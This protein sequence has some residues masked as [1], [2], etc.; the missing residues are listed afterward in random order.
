MMRGLIKIYSHRSALL[1][2]TVALIMGLG[3]WAAQWKAKQAERELR[4]GLLQQ[5]T[6]IA[7]TIDPE[8]VKVLTFTDSDK[9]NAAFDRI[10]RQMVAYRR[11]IPQCA[12]YSMALRNETIIFGPESHVEPEPSSGE[13]SSYRAGMTYEQPSDG[14]FQAFRV[15]QPITIGPYTDEYGVFISGLAP[16]LD[17]KTREVVLVVG[18]DIMYDQWSSKIAHARYGPIAASLSLI[19]IIV[20]GFMLTL[21]RNCLSVWW[22][23]RLRHIETA[24]VAAICMFLTIFITRIAIEI[25]HNSLE[26]TFYKYSDARAAS[27]RDSFRNVNTNI[28]ALGR[29]FEYDSEISRDDFDRFTI[30]MLETSSIFAYQWIPTVSFKKKIDVETTAAAESIE[31][32][33]IWELNSAGEKIKAQTRDVYYPIRHISPSEGNEMMIGFDLGSEKLRRAAIEKAADTK[34][35]TATDPVIL[36]QQKDQLKSMLI[37]RPVFKDTVHSDAEPNIGTH[38]SPTLTGF[39]SAVLTMQALF[40]N[41]IKDNADLSSLIDTDILDVMSEPPVVLAHT[42]QTPTRKIVKGKGSHQIKQIY[43]LFAFDRSFAIISYPNE[44]FYAQNRPVMAFITGSS[45]L[46]ITIILTT[47]IGFLRNHQTVLENQVKQRTNDIREREERLSTTLN[48]IGDAV[49]ATDAAGNIT[50]MNPVAEELT[51]WTFLEADGRPLTEIFIIRNSTTNEPVSDPVREVLETGNVVGMANHTSLIS[52][53]GTQRQIADSAAPIRQSDGSI[54]GVVLVFH[55][56]TE[57][58]RMQTTLIESEARFRT[59]ANSGQ[60]LVWTSGLDKKCDYLNEP[61]L[62][63]TGSTLD[64]QKAYDRLD[65]VHPDDREAMMDVYDKSFDLREKFNIEYRLRRQDG[66]YRWI[67]D[68]GTPRYDSKGEFLGYI[69]HCIDINERVNAQLRLKQAKDELEEANIRLQEAATQ[70]KQMAIESQAAN[71]AKGQFLANMSHEIRTPM[72]GVIGMTLLLMETELDEEQRRYAEIVCSSGKA[73]LSLINEILDFSK[74]EADKL[75]LES[76]EFNLREII[77][78]TAE[79]LAFRAQEKGLELVSRIEPRLQTGLIGDP[80]RLRQVLI[81][82]GGNAV[83]FTSEGEIQINAMLESETDTQ[84]IVRFEVQD[85][86]IGIPVDKTHLLFNPFQQVDYSHTRKFSGTGLGLAISKRLVELFG[87]EIGVDSV[88]GQGSVF[89]FTARIDKQKDRKAHDGDKFHSVKGMRILIVDDNLTS[90]KVLSEQLSVWGARCKVCSQAADAVEV[91]VSA[92]SA[93]DP[94]TIAM[95]DMQMPYMDGQSLGK[96]VKNNPPIEN[97]ILIMMV[98]PC[99]PE[100]TVKN[101]EIGFSGMIS[102]P[103]KRYCL[104]ETLASALGRAANTPPKAPVDPFAIRYV[105]SDERRNDIRILLAED[106]PINQKVAIGMLKKLGLHTDAVTNGQ[107]AI[108]AIKVRHYDLIFMDVQM[109]V[110]DGLTATRQIRCGHKD[111]KNPDIPIIAMTANAIKGDREQCIEAGMNDYIPKPVMPNIL[112][113]VLKEW[114]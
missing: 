83:K 27:I 75:E 99:R 49:I 17:P 74:I 94:F 78:E 89:W 73:M 55:D 51:G 86:G 24:F 48:S 65:C 31:L 30:P 36:V 29:F 19:A 52:R 59:L 50:R 62:I 18:M 4:S 97:T 28:D 101:K 112:A 3:L 41:N 40:D 68:V 96:A 34:L 37:F 106:N 85:S 11:L 113:E 26:N 20:A 67:Q 1:A 76:V 16:V 7:L 88:E 81:N 110:M 8:L 43:P 77:E 98:S 45:G 23:Q 111:I 60:A 57:Q 93:G 102:K 79:M 2:V 107:E 15:T 25:D 114:L 12:I 63:F 47:F 56:V 22:Q 84:V 42:G 69:G 95:I 35:G 10:R 9:D 105:I 87:G 5:T 53:G 13:L 39:V 14:H 44:A 6:E 32:S 92:K 64:E 82:L 72:N 109:P 38:K 70:A 103:V 61:W 104:K 66:E 58:Y 33:S 91:L 54:L 90:G 71:M 46:L 80:G 108:D 100:D 21:Y